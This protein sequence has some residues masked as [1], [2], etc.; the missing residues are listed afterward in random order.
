MRLLLDTPV[1]LWWLGDSRRLGRRTHALL[2]SPE[3]VVWVSAGVT[4]EIAIKVGLGRLDLGEPPEVCLPRE[5]ERSGFQLLPITI[6]HSLAA[7]S[8]P[9]IHTDPFDRILIAQALLEGMTLVTADR[10]IARYPVSQLDAS[11]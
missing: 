8:L 3:T 7:R 11:I 2:A 1:L 9:K 5:L 6:E 10:E 4:W